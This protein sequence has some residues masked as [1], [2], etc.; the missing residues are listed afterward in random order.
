[1]AFV[2]LG[3]KLSFSLSV[4]ALMTLNL[5]KGMLS[6]PGV[7]GQLSDLIFSAPFLSWADYLLQGWE[8][9]ADDL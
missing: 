6:L 3:K 9:S 2:A 5:S 7:S 1:M 4:Y 8:K